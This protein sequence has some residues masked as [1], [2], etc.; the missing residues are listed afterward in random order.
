MQTNE[1]PFQSWVFCRVH[2]AINS[3]AWEL[4][5]AHVGREHMLYFYMK[6]IFSKFH[7]FHLWNSVT[8]KLLVIAGSSAVICDYVQTI[9][10]KYGHIFKNEEQVQ[11]K[12]Y[13]ILV[14]IINLCKLLYTE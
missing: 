5:I 2:W 7:M 9:D 1:Q 14:F 12:I 10:H 11:W 13:K 4:N 6:V 3:I 8:P